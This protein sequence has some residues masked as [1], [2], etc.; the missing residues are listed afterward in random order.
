MVVIVFLAAI[1]AV[2]AQVVF[3][4]FTADTTVDSHSYHFAAEALAVGANPYDTE[5]L[6]DLAPDHLGFIFP[7]VYPPVLAQLWRPLLGLGPIGAHATMMGLGVV[8]GILHGLLVWRL[9][10]PATNP[11]AW[12]LLFIAV[13]AV[14]GP[15]ISTIRL[16]QVNLLLSTLVVG[17]LH[18]ERRDRPT[19][20][21]LLLALAIAIK[22]TPVVVLLDLLLR[23][24]WATLLRTAGFGLALVLGSIALSGIDP[25]LA[26]VDRALDPLPFNPPISLRGFVDGL[27]TVA[28]LPRWLTGAIFFAA[29]TGILVR[30]AMRVPRLLAPDP[31]ASWS[32]LI[33]F[34]LLAFPLTWHHHYVSAI[35]PLAYFTLRSGDG[36]ITG[37]TWL[38]LLVAGA[39][40]LRYPGVFH[41]VKPLASM[42][43]LV[44][45]RPEDQPRTTRASA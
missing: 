27:G 26:F 29:L 17:A 14:M 38:W 1:T 16:G 7:Y 11:G 35:L 13:H 12:L 43:G 5:L 30:L 23:R 45:V 22:L 4:P 32:V 33:L 37:R 25:W 21:G 9:V 34:G 44:L 3:R 41:A 6:Q 31:T 39:A 2:V 18:L 8:L 36:R 40:L 42:L 24:R 15:V 19:G 10:R 20:A 28:A